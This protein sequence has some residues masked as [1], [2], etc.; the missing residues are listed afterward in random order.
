MYYYTR[1]TY[2][3][4]YCTGWSTRQGRAI[5][6]NRFLL[7]FLKTNIFLPDTICT[8]ILRYVKPWYT[9]FSIAEDTV[10]V[11]TGAIDVLLHISVST[12][13]RNYLVWVVSDHERPIGTVFFFSKRSSMTVI[14]HILPD[15]H[16]IQCQ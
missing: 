16:V 11:V 7:L 2:Y 4:Y 12:G 1:R 6:C 8:V 5:D 9:L 14:W 15:R 13:T 3:Y 10:L